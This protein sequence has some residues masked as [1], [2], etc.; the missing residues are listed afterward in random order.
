[1]AFK[2]KTQNK[3]GGFGV[4]FAGYLPAVLLTNGFS[5]GEAETGAGFGFVSLVETVKDFFEMFFFDG[6]AV[7]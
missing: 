2:L 1:M 4:A 7:V 6:S 3:L 5:N